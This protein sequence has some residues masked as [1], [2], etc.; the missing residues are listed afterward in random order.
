MK[1]QRRKFFSSLGVDGEKKK[2]TQELAASQVFKAWV[3]GDFPPTAQ[4]FQNFFSSVRQNSGLVG[5]SK[6]VGEFGVA[7]HHF[8][9]YRMQAVW[10]ESCC[11]RLQKRKTAKAG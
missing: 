8:S 11:L 1:V 3:V 4:L 2:K 6:A 9:T 5:W 7:R 10:L